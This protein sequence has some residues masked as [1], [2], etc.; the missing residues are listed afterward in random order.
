MMN[1][2]LTYDHA[3]GTQYPVRV[4]ILGHLMSGKTTFFRMLKEMEPRLMSYE[5][6]SSFPDIDD[7]REV[8]TLVADSSGMLMDLIS[9]AAGTTAMKATHIFWVDAGGRIEQEDGYLYPIDFDPDRMIMVD[10]SQDLDYLREEA[11]MCLELLNL[12][13]ENADAEGDKTE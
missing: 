13:P 10:N 9:L 5:M 11:T 1:K 8:N 12:I 2:L 3:S 6:S 7:A 4:L